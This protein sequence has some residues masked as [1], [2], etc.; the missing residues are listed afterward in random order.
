[1]KLQQAGVLPTAAHPVVILWG[2]PGA[3]KSTVARWL[4]DEKGYEHVENDKTALKGVTTD[5]EQAWVAVPRG[6]VSPA[7]FVSAAQRRGRPVVV[8]YGLWARRPWIDLLR[9]LQVAGAEPWWFDGDR[10]AA[11]AAWR[12][13]NR[14]SSRPF[15]DNAWDQV[16]AE[17]DANWPML[18]ELFGERIIRTIEPGP[19]YRSPA[20]TF[21][22][23]TAVTRRQLAARVR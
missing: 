3:G 17:I 22:A 21:A 1:M 15:P 16:V 19:V 20:E 11:K 13:D 4:R 6:Q 8:E 14:K 10:V 12:E 5:L 2:V 23:M 18:A 9:R 7:A